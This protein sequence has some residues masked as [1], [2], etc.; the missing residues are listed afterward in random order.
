MFT[1]WIKDEFKVGK[2]KLMWQ[3]E[4]EI[5]RV[6]KPGLLKMDKYKRKWRDLR[7]W[8]KNEVKIDK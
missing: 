8:E 7:K 5:I 4:K 2:L 1:V 6:S 3:K